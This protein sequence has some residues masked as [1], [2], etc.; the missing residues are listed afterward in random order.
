MATLKPSGKYTCVKCES[1]IKR[2]AVSDNFYEKWICP[3]CG[4]VNKAK[5]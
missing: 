1:E 2:I 5:N 4:E 3:K